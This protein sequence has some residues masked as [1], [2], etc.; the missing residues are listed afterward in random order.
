[1][2]ENN[3]NQLNNAT[4]IMLSVSTFIKELQK[5]TLKVLPS[6]EKITEDFVKTLK[7]FNENTKIFEVFETIKAASIDPESFLNWVDYCLKLSEFFWIIPFD[8]TSKELY[9]IL[10]VVDNEKDFDKRI[11]KYFTKAKV[12]GLITEIKKNLN[13]KY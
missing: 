8:I 2:N 1:M 12:I 13:P 6:I 4:N 9:D 11:S 7:A 10:E 3:N 5:Y